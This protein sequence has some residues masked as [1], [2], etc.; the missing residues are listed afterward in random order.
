M[1]IEE[2]I[3]EEW[4]QNSQVSKSGI[5]SLASIGPRFDQYWAN[6]GQYSYSPKVAEERKL[7]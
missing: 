6:V 3:K 4:M 1:I 2:K 5:S 7:K